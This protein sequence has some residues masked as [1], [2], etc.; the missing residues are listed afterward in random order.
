MMDLYTETHFINWV[1]KTVPEE[2]QKETIGIIL[3][4]LKDY[5]EL[6][7]QGYSWPEIRILAERR[8]EIGVK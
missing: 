1:A 4:F 2:H 8:I 5:P 3:D 6:I 7:E